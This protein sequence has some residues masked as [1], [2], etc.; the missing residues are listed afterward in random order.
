MEDSLSGSSGG[1]GWAPLLLLPVLEALV[2]WL[3]LRSGGGEMDNGLPGGV[4]AQA[5]VFLGVCCVLTVV[6]LVRT[7]R[8][9]SPSSC[10]SFVTCAAVIV[11]VGL[12]PL[13]L[14][15]Y[16]W[17]LGGTA[18]LTFF[19]GLL[20][21]IYL[22]LSG[23]VMAPLLLLVPLLELIWGEVCAWALWR[24][25]RVTPATAIVCG[26]LQPVMLVGLVALVVL[27]IKGRKRRANRG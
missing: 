19:F 4:F 17:I 20:G 23:Y 5:G 18:F 21:P 16:A 12:V 15:V 26:L 14:Y 25:Q 7:V 6:V 27:A 2:P 24:A 11:R 9:A 3:I 8:Q 1:R 22:L 13:V 10:A